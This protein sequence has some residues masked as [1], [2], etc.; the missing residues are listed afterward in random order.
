MRITIRELLFLQRAECK[1]KHHFR[2][3][4]RDYGN[5][6]WNCP[7][8]REYDGTD[9]HW[10]HPY[11]KIRWP[12]RPVAMHLR[13]AAGNHTGVQTEYTG[14]WSAF[15]REERAIDAQTRSCAR[16]GDSRR[17][18]PRK[19]QSRSPKKVKQSV[20][21]DGNPAKEQRS[22]HARTSLKT[23][24]LPK[25]LD[26]TDGLAVAVCHHF[27]LRGVPTAARS[28]PVGKPL[29]RTILRE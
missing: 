28:I 21:G 2:G 8:R 3:W 9:S 4:P 15:F 7:V 10:Q 13:P 6:I 23:D 19:Y 27:S 16:D 14:Y 25:Q 24:V 5:R 1:E 26:A 22:R 20:T 29:P 17:T 11:R 12:L 18:I